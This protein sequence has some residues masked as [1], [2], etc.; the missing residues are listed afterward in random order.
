MAE[1]AM[2]VIIMAFGAWAIG[3]L[4]MLA[5]AI[6]EFACWAPPTLWRFLT[7]PMGDN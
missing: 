6:L 3:V 4:L 2:F 1:L 5:L 7:K